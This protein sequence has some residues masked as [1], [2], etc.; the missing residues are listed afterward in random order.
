[1]LCTVG[2]ERLLHRPWTRLCRVQF[3]W[4]LGCY[5]MQWHEE[6]CL[7][8]HRGFGVY[9]CILFCLMIC[10][11]T[12]SAVVTFTMIINTVTD[13]YIRFAWLATKTVDCWK[14]LEQDH[15]HAGWCPVSQPS[16]EVYLVCNWKAVK[17]S[18]YVITGLYYNTQWPRRHLTVFT[19]NYSN[20]WLS[21]LNP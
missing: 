19:E 8:K 3:T 20:Q 1:M 7:W 6:K 17:C 12:T 4:R 5:K 15:T 14:A 9:S 13:Y 10:T 11:L 16:C 21:C 2:W 18:L